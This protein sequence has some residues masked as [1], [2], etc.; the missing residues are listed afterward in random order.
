MTNDR[1]TSPEPGNS[2]IARATGSGTV[3]GTRLPV[4][5]TDVEIQTPDGLCDAGFLYP[6]T[7][8]HPGVLVWADAFGL[9]PAMRDLG[10]RLAAEGYAVLV[11]NPF[12]RSAQPPVLEGPFSFQNPADRAKLQ[13][14]VAP[15][16]A[17]GAVAR[18]NESR[19]R[20][21]VPAHR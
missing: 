12:Y 6:P 19:G 1:Q 3:S 7:G 21:T 13:Q 4:V 20:R 8:T 18:D 5:E 11:P 9:R 14:L 16:H 10:K 17:P 2:R 15:L